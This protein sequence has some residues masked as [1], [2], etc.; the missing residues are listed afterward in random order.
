MTN[1]L[2]YVRL[3]GMP[4][5]AEVIPGFSAPLNPEERAYLADMLA[6]E[7]GAAL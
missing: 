3:Y 1:A 4:G 6:H 2:P 7:T 5:D